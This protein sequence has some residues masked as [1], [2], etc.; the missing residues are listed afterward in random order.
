MPWGVLT[1][2]PRL[3]CNTFKSRTAWSPPIIITIIH[4]NL[5]FLSRNSFCFSHCDDIVSDIFFNNLNHL[6]FLASEP[7]VVLPCD[8]LLLRLMFVLQACA[9][10][11]LDHLTIIS[12]IFPCLGFKFFFNLYI[13][14]FLQ[15]SFSPKNCRILPVGRRDFRVCIRF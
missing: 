13:L 15:Q 8:I 5:M 4:M 1:S 11:G 6:D 12:A 10:P 14:E 7:D 9:G 2:F 3:E